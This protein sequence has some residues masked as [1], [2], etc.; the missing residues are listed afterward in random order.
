MR[1]SRV[2]LLCLFLA[3]ASFAQLTPEQKIADLMQLAGL[4]AKNYMPYEWKRDAMGF[5]LYNVQPW[6]DKVRQSKDDIEFYDVCVRY[7]AALQDSHDEFLLPSDFEANLHFTTDIYEGKVLIDSIDRLYLRATAYPFAVGDELVSVDGV[8]AADLVQ[9]F[10]PYSANGSGSKVTRQRLAAD[11]ITLRAQA[12]YP[13]ANRIGD[14]ATVVV[15]RQ[16]GA[17]ETYTI[18]W[19]KFGTPITQVGPVPNL[20]ANI[21]HGAPARQRY[22]RHESDENPW[23]VWSGDTA[24]VVPD[25]VPP[26]MQ[27]LVDLQN[28]SGLMLREQAGF[29]SRSAVFSP[30]AGYTARLGAKLTDL[31]TSGTFPVGAHTIGFIRIW[32]M[33]PSSTTT[34]LQQFAAEIAFF[35]QNTDALVIDVMHNGG[36]S[37]C[38]T[39][40]LASYLIPQPFHG[41]A[42]MIRATQSWVES[43]SSSLFLAQLFGDQATIDAYTK[44]ISTLQEAMASSRGAAGP[45]PICGISIT[46]QPATDRSGTVLAYTKPILLLT[47]DFSLSAA[48]HF[49]AVLQDA[50]RATIFGT[51]TAGGGGSPTAFDATTYSEASTR[52]T[53]T[54]ILRAATV[55]TPDYPASEYIENTGVYP[56]IVQDYMTVDNLLNK[57]ATFVQ[58]FSAAVDKLIAQ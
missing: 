54:L 46:A 44:I 5:D 24:P 26:Y 15:R 19:D 30:P 34:A 29:G 2:L 31:F 35:Q 18:P 28:E 40:S 45:L 49:A 6:L 36:G 4:Y 17:L 25:P 42:D 33:S 3:P 16:S 57:G 10:I 11:T 39:Q 58:Q 38:Y 14:T 52:V 22:R 37:A 12:I 53:R 21:R 43:Y 47:D 8:A 1:V 20:S 27:A 51:R 23:G 13:A 55:Q 41:A 56:D 32:T 9:Q 50:Q 48:E 7:V